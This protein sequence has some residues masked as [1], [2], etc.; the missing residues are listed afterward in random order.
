[1]ATGHIS[2]DDLELYGLDRLAGVDAASAEE[3]LLVCQECREHL[4]GWDEYVRSMRAAMR[5]PNNE[6]CG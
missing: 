5:L 1:M 2:D 6:P 4:A 3:H